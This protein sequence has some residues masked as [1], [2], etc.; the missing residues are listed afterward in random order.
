MV[1]LKG[2]FL[3]EFVYESIACLPMGDLDILIREPTH[4]LKNDSIKMTKM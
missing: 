4:K 2:C 3:A 1:I